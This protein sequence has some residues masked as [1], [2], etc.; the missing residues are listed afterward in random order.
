MGVGG[1]FG[2][3][4]GVVLDGGY[5]VC[6]VGGGEVY[7]VGECKLCLVVDVSC[8]WSGGVSCVWWWGL[9]GVWWGVGGGVCG[10]CGTVVGEWLC[11]LVRGC[12]G[13]YP[14]SDSSHVGYEYGHYLTLSYTRSCLAF[15][16]Y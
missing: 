1:F 10:G 15:A 3:C 2:G 5:D 8:V 9:G 12:G 7:L 6:L 16:S 11:L 4:G 14:L 13:T